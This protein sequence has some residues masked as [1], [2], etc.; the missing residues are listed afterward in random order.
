MEAQCRSAAVSTAA[1]AAPAAWGPQA[2]TA[3]SSVSVPSE[4]GLAAPKSPAAAAAPQPADDRRAAAAPAWGEAV[5]AVV[6]QRF[7]ALPKTGRPQAHEHTVLA[8]FAVSLSPGVVAGSPL[9]PPPWLSDPPAESH[10]LAPL[11]AL[12][13]D[14]PK[15]PC[16]CCLLH[17]GGGGGHAAAG[18]ASHI[19]GLG[20]AAAAGVRLSEAAAG[21][22]P[23]GRVETC[24]FSSS[25]GAAEARMAAAA[26]PSPGGETPDG[27]AAAGGVRVVALGTGSKCL[28]VAARSPAGDVVND[29][30]AEVVA[31]RALQRWLHAE[32]AVAL[33]AAAPGAPGAGPALER[34][35]AGRAGSS[36]EEAPS[37]WLHRVLCF[38]EMSSAG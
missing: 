22:A 16:S 20:A 15:V 35:G 37:P 25:A 13:T 8:G 12:R 32:L 34:G 1:T 36:G 3:A 2:A 31:R 23:R 14:V 17:A 33:C 10:Q 26:W 21:A 5:A 9:R 7:A 4:A 24:Q 38:Q 11:P 28:G 19:A 29:S 18:A 6:Q 30:H 27:V